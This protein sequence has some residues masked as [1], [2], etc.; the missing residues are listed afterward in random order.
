MVYIYRGLL[1]IKKNE[2]NTI[3]SNMH[4]PRDSHTKWSKPEEE[5]QIPYDATFVWTVKHDTNEL[6]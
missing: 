5:R 6:I 1:A 3:Y 2:N 4:G